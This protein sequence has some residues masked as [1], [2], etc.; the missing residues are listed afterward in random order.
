MSNDDVLA[1]A[2]AGRL[3]DWSAL[4]SRRRGHCERVARLLSDW[5][6]GLGLPAADVMRWQAAARLHDAVKDA[7]AADLR[8]IV[9]EPLRTLPDA[10]LHG[11]A[12]AARLRADGV[13]DRAL[14]D[15]IAWHT[16]GHADLEPIGHA[17]YVADFIEPGRH[18]LPDTLATW[19]A[20]MPAALPDAVRA[21]V[22]MRM[23]FLLG[24]G[25]PIR[26]ETVAFWNALT[27]SAGKH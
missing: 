8:R 18:Y 20:R 11:H 2:A 13:T 24:H 7:P 25:R 21:V 26:A 23:Q 3:P 9:D 5:A 19:R 27:A 16:T 15:A 17:L 10:L 22:R 1:A 14:L 6:A 4:T 12:A